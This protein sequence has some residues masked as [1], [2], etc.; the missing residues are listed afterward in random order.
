MPDYGEN[1][2]LQCYAPSNDTNVEIKDAFYDHLE[3]ELDKASN[4]DIKIKGDLTSKV[5]SGNVGLPSAILF[6]SP[7]LVKSLQSSFI[8][9]INKLISNLCMLNGS[10]GAC[11]SIVTFVLVVD[12]QKSMISTNMTDVSCSG[13]TETLQN[14]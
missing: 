14:E 9:H 2:I 12:V 4:H 8:L 10:S 5:G 6:P 1:S 13:A 11:N 7:T 3:H